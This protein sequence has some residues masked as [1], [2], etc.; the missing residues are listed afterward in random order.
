MVESGFAGA[1]AIFDR[2][3][4]QYSAPVPEVEGVE[5]GASGF[6]LDGRAVQF[7]QAKTTPTKVGQFVTVWVRSVAGPI[8]PFDVA[9]GVSLFIVAV[10]D[11]DGEGHFVFPAEVLRVRGIVSSGGVGGKRA[12]RVYPPW[13]AGLNGQATRTQEWQS[14]FFLETHPVR[15]GDVD[16]VRALYR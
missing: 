4:F 1:A 11:S 9:D 7:R 3:G 16:R 14:E 2:H 10:S 8:R 6:V 13:L 5:Y 12:F 15:G